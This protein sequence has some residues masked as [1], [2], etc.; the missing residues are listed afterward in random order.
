MKTKVF[1]P[2]KKQPVFSLLKVM[3]KGAENILSVIK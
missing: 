1:K 2:P 3:K